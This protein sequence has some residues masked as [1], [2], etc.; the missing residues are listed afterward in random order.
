MR[1]L[2]ELFFESDDSLYNAAVMDVLCASLR[3]MLP[4]LDVPGPHYHHQLE[5]LYFAGNDIR[6]LAAAQLFKVLATQ[7]TLTSVQIK[8]N[9]LFESAEAVRELINLMYSENTTLLSLNIYWDVTHFSELSAI[10]DALVDNTTL[11]SLFLP[12]D[13][14][15]P[16]DSVDCR[17][18]FCTAARRGNVSC[19]LLNK[20]DSRLQNCI[21]HASWF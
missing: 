17:C 14:S 7:A 13:P 18:T 3:S 6:P 15:A 20:R 5:K 12:C 1:S 4:R 16:I 8:V 21:G 19:S 2:R 10:H 9:R 11:T